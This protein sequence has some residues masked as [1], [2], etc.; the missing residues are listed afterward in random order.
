M[1]LVPG[2]V[3]RL[4]LLRLNR[5][6]GPMLDFL[7]AQAFRAACVAVELGVFEA[8]GGGPLTAA[9]IARRAKANERGTTLLLEALAALGYVKKKDGRYGN[10][11][12]T[13]KWLLRASPTSLA[14]GIPFLESMVFERWAHLGESIRRGKPVVYGSEWLDRHPGNYRVYEEGMVAGARMAAGEVVARVKLP[15]AARRLLDLGGGHGLYSI[16]FCRRHPGL[17][18]TV[19][20]LPQALEVARETV[21]AEGM[22]N[23]V[24]VQDGDFL[25]DAIGAGYDAA[26]VFNI[27]HAFPSDKNAEL[28]NKVSGALNREG[29]VVIMEQLAGEV[30]GPTARAFARLQGLNY[31]NDL[32]GQVYTFD[33]I[34]G[35]LASAGFT[36]LRRIHLRKA[37]GF[38]LVLGTKTDAG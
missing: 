18:A 1:P 26:L 7:G 8:L 27:L 23:R 6:P 29:R 32:E 5:G 4:V 22:G 21:V 14:G 19:F 9:E 13:A 38:S 24:A 30:P 35:W 37:P 15:P 10:T 12:M 11:P 34:A 31:F 20:D 33:E 36:H 28:L 25:A 16:E 3:E 17:S 2:P